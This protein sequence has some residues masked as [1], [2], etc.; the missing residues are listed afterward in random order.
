[1]M[2]LNPFCKLTLAGCL[3]L[4]ANPV[5]AEVPPLVPEPPLISETFTS[6]INDL[7][8]PQTWAFTFWPTDQ[9]PDSYGDG[10][11]WLEGNSES[12]T[13]V[14]PL[15]TK[16]NGQAVPPDLRYNPFRRA[17]DGLH[18][19]AS[20]LS[21]DQQSAYQVD[22]HRRF[23]SGMLRSRL[24]F[25]YGSIRIVA[26]LPT[27][28]GSW[29]AAWLMPQ[30]RVWPPE[31]DIFEGMI[32]GPHVRQVHLG[33]LPPRSESTYQFK[34]WV[35]TYFHPGTGFHEYRLDW[36]PEKVRF[37]IDGRLLASRPTPPSMKQPMYLLVNL[38]VGGK[39]PCNELGIQPI[40]GRDPERLE[41]CVSTFEND[42]PADMVIR[43]ITVLPLS[44]T[45]GTSSLKWR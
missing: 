10:T 39:W 26:K 4:M 38:A 23:G 45:Q 35:N 36:T 8:D 24:S 16:V 25:T 2:L 40:D 14:T 33:L 44:H 1:V 11:N 3:V 20:R 15:I 34:G 42:Y 13:Y 32:W 22:G 30:A 43:S 31:I 6:M 19:R 17:A 7:P 27:A 21:L 28:R 41:R 18:I 37:A 5:L 12:Q 9:W 29:A